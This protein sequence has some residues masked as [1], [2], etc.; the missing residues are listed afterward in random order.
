MVE[1]APTEKGI[2]MDIVSPRSSKPSKSQPEN[3]ITPVVRLFNR[4]AS[5]LSAGVPQQLS[6]I[7]GLR[8]DIEHHEA[9]PVLPLHVGSD[10]LLFVLNTLRTPILI[11]DRH[12]H[13]LFAN[14]AA[15]AAV[16]HGG[17]LQRCGDQLKVTAGA[18]SAR[19]FADAVGAASRGC[20]MQ[21]A[22]I[23]DGSDGCSTVIWLQPV[24]EAL[25]TSATVWSRGLICLS[26][27]ALRSQSAISQALL[28]RHYRLTPKQAEVACRVALGVSIGSVAVDM[29]IEITTLRSHLSKVF[30]KT[31]TRHQSDLVSLMLSLTSPVLE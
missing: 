16:A 2:V 22:M 5:S 17:A 25:Q 4:P 30:H 15:G 27:R 1:G 3:E 26:F 13:I 9:G 24:D 20:P 12:L 31:G 6:V 10:V 14:Q 23:L 21:R 29:N 19:R 11:V 7:D 18:E 28:I 8:Q